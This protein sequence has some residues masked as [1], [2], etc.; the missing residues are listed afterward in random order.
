MQGGG[1]EAA[2]SLWGASSRPPTS[3]CLVNK[4]AMAAA[5]TTASPKA[6]GALALLAGQQQGEEQCWVEP[7][8]PLRLAR[9][10]PRPAPSRTRLRRR[11]RGAQALR[12]R[13]GG[14]QQALGD[15]YDGPLLCLCKRDGLACHYSPARWN[16]AG[17]YWEGTGSLPAGCM[18]CW[19]AAAMGKTAAAARPHG[20][21]RTTTCYRGAWRG[22]GAAQDAH[23]RPPPPPRLASARPPRWLPAQLCHPQ[24]LREAGEVQPSEAAC[25][26]GGGSMAVGGRR[27]L[28]WRP[29]R[30]SDL[31]RGLP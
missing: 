14:E 5:F 4:T 31:D 9:D 19:L 21:E 23:S 26:R 7:P 16:R 25:G 28:E 13:L 30:T 18:L 27:R 3:P 10:P 24:V 20:V 22:R 17:R 8:R 29:Y 2:G 12:C 1:R 11:Q 15:G 6:G